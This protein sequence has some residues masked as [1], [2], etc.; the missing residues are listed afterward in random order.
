[1]ARGIRYYYFC[2]TA[3]ACST[4]VRWADGFDG[5]VCGCGEKGSRVGRRGKVNIFKA[6]GRVIMSV[7]G[8]LCRGLKVI[9]EV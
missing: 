7:V 5:G 4:F 1:M 2:V 9:S 8:A 6:Q 3:G